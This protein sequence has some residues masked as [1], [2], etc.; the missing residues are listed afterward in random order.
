V[1]SAGPAEG[2]TTV[3]CCIA[4]AMAQAVLRVVLLDC[5][6][7]RPRLHRV[8][9]KS[10]EHGVTTSLLDGTLD[11]A[12]VPTD[13]PNLSIVPAGPLPPNPAEIVQSERFRTAL[14]D[15]GDHFDRIVI[16]SPPV[17]PVTDATILSTL[18]DGTVLVV[19]GFVTSKELARQAVRA[20]ADVGGKISGIV[21][22][23]IDLDRHEYKYAYYY[24]KR[25][26]YYSA[27]GTSG[28]RNAPAP[29]TPDTSA[30]PPN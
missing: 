4:I 22:N 3:A 13:V 17:V 27:D 24:Y 10:S 21:L 9:G 1:T 26:G 14:R 5:D 20:L 16:D 29:A 30:M 15:L 11:Q 19:K 8:F 23:A 18:V 28:K 7:R 25:D 2:K 6:L 12:A